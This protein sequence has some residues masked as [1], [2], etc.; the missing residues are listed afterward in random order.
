[1]M[2][3]IVKQIG[4]IWSMEKL[5]GGSSNLIML[6]LIG[7]VYLPSVNLK[8]KF[9]NFIPILIFSSKISA[10]LPFI[11]SFLHPEDSSNDRI[12]R[13]LL[14]EKMKYIH[15]HHIQYRFSLLFTTFLFYEQFVG[16][17]VCYMHD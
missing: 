9:S 14:T 8:S 3:M 13:W 16:S 11:C 1:M 15:S 5:D 4:M 10:N 7:M 6:M 17:L 12:Q 2:L